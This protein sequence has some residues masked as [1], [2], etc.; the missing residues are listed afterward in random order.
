MIDEAEGYLELN[1]PGHA[2]RIIQ[3]KQHAVAQSCYLRYLRARAHQRCGN[4]QK[5]IADLK[6]IVERCPENPRPLIVLGSCYKRVG[7]IWSALHALHE[8]VLLEPQSALIH[9]NLACY[10]SLVR[11]KPQSL[12]YLKNAIDIDV[13]LRKCLRQDDDF[14][15]LQSDPVFSAMASEAV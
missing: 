3:R 11:C 6:I 10:W 5:A 14:A 2:L 1:L 12:R 13:T 4:H 7:K 9:Y 8:A 15:F